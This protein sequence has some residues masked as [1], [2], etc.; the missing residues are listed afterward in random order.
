MEK[1][2]WTEQMNKTKYL[3]LSSFFENG[4]RIQIRA[5]ICNNGT[6]LNK[7]RI[8]IDCNH[9]LNASKRAA[10]KRGLGFNLISL[11]FEDCGFHHVNRND[12]V[13]IDKYTHRMFDHS[14]N[15]ES[16]LKIEG[17]IG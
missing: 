9:S 6:F 1:D 3:P 11:P 2:I 7:S 16:A 8:D 5:R 4:C 17:V 10:K 12:V 13:A 14:L 15:D